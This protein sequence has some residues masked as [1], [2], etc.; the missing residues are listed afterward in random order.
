MAREYTS[1]L[2]SK[3]EEQLPPAS[4]K[5][6]KPEDVSL[7]YTE[8]PLRWFSCL[9]YNNGVS[10]ASFLSNN[11]NDLSEENIDDLLRSNV[12]EAEAAFFERHLELKADLENAKSLILARTQLPTRKQNNAVKRFLKNELAKGRLVRQEF[13]QIWF[14]RM[15]TN[16]IIPDLSGTNGV[17]YDC[18]AFEIKLRLLKSISEK[19][20]QEIEDAIKIQCLV[21]TN[22]STRK[23]T[24]LRTERNYSSLVTF[25]LLEKEYG[26][27]SVRI[28]G[29]MS[30]FLAD[31]KKW[32]IGLT[33]KTS[34]SHPE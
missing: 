11:I 6:L 3:L 25:K 18:C 10:N 14:L 21:R 23:C 30:E 19:L 27:H 2:F 1:N 9:F 5:Q 20:S 22:R 8:Y 31:P 34:S 33:N 26:I 13:A 15:K 24:E 4:V 29:V 7:R 12:G 16:K 17:S 32:G 28:R